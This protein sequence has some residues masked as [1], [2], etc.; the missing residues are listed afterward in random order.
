MYTAQQYKQTMNTVQQEEHVLSTGHYC[1]LLKG[2]SKQVYKMMTRSSRVEA[3]RRG[4]RRCHASR[5]QGLIGVVTSKENAG[6]FIF[7][8]SPNFS[9]WHLIE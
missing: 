9:F 7:C 4:H 2:V 8:G 6:I 3:Q 5:D 1:F